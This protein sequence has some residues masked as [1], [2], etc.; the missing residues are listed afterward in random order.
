MS[1]K[2][3]HSTH[4]E[5]KVRNQGS[6]LSWKEKLTGL[7]TRYE[8]FSA[9]KT[10]KEAFTLAKEVISYFNSTLRFG[11]SPRELVGVQKIETEVKIIDLKEPK[12]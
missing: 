12:I 10:D 1:E 6:E 9:P 4:Y 7:K 3:I 2:T 11:E 8:T 5:I